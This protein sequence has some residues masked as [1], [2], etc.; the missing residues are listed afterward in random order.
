MIYYDLRDV[1]FKFIHLMPTT[2]KLISIL[3]PLPT[4]INLFDDERPLDLKRWVFY[5]V[6]TF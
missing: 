5:I 4:F 2:M 3:Q 6:Y 1:Y